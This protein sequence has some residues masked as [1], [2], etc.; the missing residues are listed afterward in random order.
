MTTQANNILSRIIQQLGVPDQS[1]ASQEIVFK[2]IIATN[3]YSNQF[4]SEEKKSLGLDLEDMLLRCSYNG[5]SCSASDF[6]WF[7]DLWYGN[8]FKFN[9][10]KNSSLH[11]V[12]LKESNKAGLLDGLQLELFIPDS[13]AKLNFE[14]NKG[15]HVL[16]HNHSITPSF[17]EG[18]NIGT[19][20]QTDVIVNRLFTKKHLI[21]IVIAQ[22]I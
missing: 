12:P 3:A 21:L 4:K 20:M 22:I 19:E 5:L 13:A 16:V 11:D 1:I 17:F 7:Y 14:F 2:L 6:E 8:C 15:I 10:G 18:I 9:S